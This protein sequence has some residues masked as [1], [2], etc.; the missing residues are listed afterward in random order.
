M[1]YKAILD[2]LA[3]SLPEQLLM[4][5]FAWVL[6]GRKDRVFL[7]ELN[8]MELLRLRDRLQIC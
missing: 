4:A 6:L 2:F 3:V 1:G 8:V 5:L 7:P